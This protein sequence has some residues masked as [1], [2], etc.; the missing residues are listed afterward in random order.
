MKI[1]NFSLLPEFLFYCLILVLPFEEVS[2]FGGVSITKLVGAAFLVT[3]L[4]SIKVFYGSIPSIFF[5]FFVYVSISMIMDII[6]LP[7]DLAALN[8][9]L[10]PLLMCLL[11]IVT[12]NIAREK[13]AHRIVIALFISALVFSLAQ[14][15]EIDVEAKRTGEMVSGR[16][17]DRVSALHADQNFAACYFSMCV[18]AGF[19]YI[20]NFVSKKWFYPLV[21][22]SKPVPTR[23]LYSSLALASSGIGF[24]AIIK[25][26]SRGGLAALFLGMLCI[27][28]TT[29]KFTRKIKYVCFTGIFL[30]SMAV[31][32]MGNPLIMTRINSTV[33]TGET[34]G[35][36][37]IWE[38][39]INLIAESPVCGY[40]Y[41]MH[42]YKLGHNTGGKLRRATHNTFL[43]IA[44]SSGLVGL[45]FFLYFVYGAF[46][47]IWVHKTAG[48]NT[49]ILPWF[50]M[51]LAA[52]FSL[53]MEITKWFWIILALGLASGNA[54]GRRPSY[55][56]AGG[57]IRRASFRRSGGNQNLHEG[58][59]RTAG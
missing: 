53:N 32:I 15:L 52:C 4:T 26:A 38:A 6:S 13:K 40:G 41:Q 14:I 21:Y 10:T 46:K 48:V 45:S 1:I 8:A 50:V 47:T 24:Y 29:G 27:P 39:A 17:L 30:A 55:A 44:L 20:A 36:T 18:I 5:A 11:M 51:S 7:L 22:D 42:L 43:T 16:M 37:E 3:S 2:S 9:L 33:E 23:W 31:V 57:T 28:L 54:G 35:R 59:I 49:V 58:I 56:A 19:G 25:T 12:Y 34:A